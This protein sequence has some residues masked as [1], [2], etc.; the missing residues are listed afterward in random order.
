MCHTHTHLFC[1]RREGLQDRMTHLHTARS[2]SVLNKRRKTDRLIYTSRFVRVI[3]SSCIVLIRPRTV[4]PLRRSGLRVHVRL[5]GPASAG[6]PALVQ[7]V[8]PALA[9]AVLPARLQTVLPACFV[10][11]LPARAIPLPASGSAP[12]LVIVGQTSARFTSPSPTWRLMEDL[13]AVLSARAS[14]MLL[15][16]AVFLIAQAAVLPANISNV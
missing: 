10:A 2:H 15:A 1:A 12:T 4:T 16:L 8:L 3:Y 13:Q 14:A 5:D 9:L 7:A 6:L 11:V